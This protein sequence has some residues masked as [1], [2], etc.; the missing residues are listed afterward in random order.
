MHKY[1]LC[2]NGLLLNCVFASVAAATPLTSSELEVSNTNE[3]QIPQLSEI[4]LHHK[5]ADLLLQSSKDSQT[6]VQSTEQSQL[7]TPTQ[8]DIDLDV[9]GTPI[10]VIE[11]RQ[12]SPTGVII[13]DQREIKRYGHR[14]IGEALRRQPGVILG[15]PPGEDKDVRLLGLPKEYT[16]ILIDGQRFPDGGENREFKVDRIPVDL[17]ERIE[18]ISNPTATQNSQGVGGTVNI[19]LKKSPD[20][21]LAELSMYGALLKESPFGGFNF[22]YGDK[23]GNFGYILNGGIQGRESPKNKF[24][25]T[26]D[27]QNRPTQTEREQENKSQLDMSFAPRF[28]WQVSPK[29]TLIFEPLFL[30]TNEEKDA[31]RNIGT[32]RFYSNGRTQEFRDQTVKIDEDKQIRGWRLSGG[33]ERQLSQNADIRLGLLFQRT[34]ETKDKIETTTAITTRFRDAVNSPVN[35]TP[36][37]SGAVKREDEKKYD[38]ELLGTLGFN[39]RLSAAHRLS[40]GIEGSLRDR[41]KNKRTFEQTLA[42]TL[43]AEVERSN[44]K[45]VY[46][47]EE[48]Q[49]NAFLQ[50]EIRLGNQHTLIA[51]IRMEMVDNTATARDNTSISQ[52]G[53]VFN[54][55]LHYKYEISPNTIFRASAARTIRRPKFDDLIPF[56]ESKNGSLLNPDVIGNPNLEPETSLGFETGI[57]H[58]WGN[59]NNIIGLNGFY[60]WID[61]KIEP[62]INR[63]PA[64]NRFEQSPVNVGNGKVYG[65]RVDAQTRT[66]FLGLPNLTLLGNISF[67]GSELEDKITRSIRRFNEQPSYVINLGFDYLIPELNMNIGVNYNYFPGTEK[68][69]FKDGNF[70]VET[71]ENDPS[72]DA[73]IAFN[74][75]DNVR[76]R[77]FGQ[78][79]LASERT[80]SISIFNTA[81][82]LQNSRF[83][84]EKSERIWGVNMSWQ[85]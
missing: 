60:R 75:R 56:R 65:L 17:V 5:K 84:T 79:L 63:N 50:D 23:V 32:S 20:R 39:W 59:G 68:R 19:V 67:L 31:I 38:Q 3:S 29:D 22:I 40:F 57:E 51:G 9:V 66:N 6:I 12:A 24:K 21:R 71:L 45:D 16:Q 44:P 58:S 72:L 47:I 62:Q 35:G 34:D 43:T 55:S 64:T 36:T 10:N 42:P 41:E 61:N 46:N 74:V 77:F 25:E 48:N 83:E 85:F 18:I 14:T 1:F 8:A 78:N 81:N 13:I 26:R 76:L 11:E 70:Q 73:Y 69:E 82:V 52:S 4:Q 2:L 28:S 33:W 15:G 7:E 54:P 80:K 27:I 37:L 53:T 49:F 30:Q